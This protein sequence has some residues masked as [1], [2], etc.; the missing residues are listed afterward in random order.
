MTQKHAVQ[1]CMNINSDNISDEDKFEAIE[2]VAYSQSNSMLLSKPYWLEITKFLLS[3]ID[4]SE[5]RTTQPEPI[6]FKPIRETKQNVILKCRFCK[7]EISKTTKYCG[8]CG[9]KID[10]S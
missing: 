7:A 5:V 1:I 3:I 8:E 9:Q 6:S 10:W 4:E 2:I